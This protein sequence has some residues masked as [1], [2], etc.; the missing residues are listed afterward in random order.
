MTLRA[1]DAG[2][3]PSDGTFDS[4]DRGRKTACRGCCRAY[5]RKAGGGKELEQ[6]WGQSPTRRLV[7]VPFSSPHP[8]HVLEELPEAH[9]RARVGG[10]L[11]YYGLVRLPM[12]V[13]RR[14]SLRRFTARARG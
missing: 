10:L 8:L 13:H 14:R 1:D 3:V 9:G 5:R 12:A 2:D 7:T 11:R 4:P 6:D